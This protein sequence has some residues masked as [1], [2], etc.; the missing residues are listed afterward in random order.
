MSI[1][2]TN[3]QVL[4][5]LPPVASSGI[6]ATA[7]SRALGF[8]KNNAKVNDA[9]AQLIDAGKV[10]TAIKGNYTVYFA[11]QTIN[12]DT[13]ATVVENDTDETSDD[14]DPDVSIKQIDGRDLP[15]NNYG[16][17]ATKT[18][19]GIIT[20]A[21]PNGEKT[22]ELEP[23]QRLVVINQDPQY[24]Y[25]VDTPEEVLAAI[26]EY[27]TNEGIHQYVVSDME[28]GR[29]ISGVEEINDSVVMIFLGIARHNK[30]GC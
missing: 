22:I 13:S 5:V 4:A 15:A 3:D 26:K 20:I 29:A 2:I 11:N 14:V 7:T 8:S 24:R 30:A 19:E 12:V 21:F 23:T 10:S 9:L 18:S 6:S 1:T 25:L 28:T 16:Y 17:N 27:T